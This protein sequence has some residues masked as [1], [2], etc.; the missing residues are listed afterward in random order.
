[1][2]PHL[3][4]TAACLAVVA[5]VVA[6][7]VVGCGGGDAPLAL[8]AA[9]S[10]SGSGTG[11][12]VAEANKSHAM[13][14]QLSA[15]LFQ[16]CGACHAIGGPA[17]TP[18]LGDPKSKNPDPYKTITSWPQFIVKD[19]KT[20]RLLTH[21]STNEHKGTKP[22]TTLVAELEA[23]LQEEAKAVK[24]VSKES[25]PTLPPFKPIVPGFN[26]V[27]LGALG[28]DFDGMAVTFQSEELTGST[29]SLTEIQIH[30]TTKK[31]L[32]I[33]HPL[34]TVFPAG[35]MDG[36]PDPVDSFSNVMQELAPGQSASLGPGKVILTNWKDGAK[37]SLAFETIAATDP[38]AGGGGAG[39]GGA[40]PGGCKAVAA[41]KANVAPSL[42]NPCFSC[43]GGANGTA[44]AAVDMKAL[45]TDPAATCAQVLNRVNVTD[46]AKSQLFVTTNPG[47]NATHP[48]KFGGNQAN[49]NNFVSSVTKWIQQEK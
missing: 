7:Q 3:R 9:S 21:P 28:P 5:V 17:D 15:Q 23:W 41:F 12:S 18:F 30:P 19:Y 22:S 24:D 49:F 2:S 6:A 47:G 16:E 44:T 39:G 46:P 33:T 8:A 27:Y 38:N 48:Y 20:S 29:L 31:G 43:H 45:M 32:K 10:G 1:M 42:A 34:F 40:S 4:W 26:A 13:F 14:D 37:L 35:S 11:G 36:Q 25:K